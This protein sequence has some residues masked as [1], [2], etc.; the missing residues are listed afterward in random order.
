VLLFSIILQPIFNWQLDFQ[1]TFIGV[2]SHG[3]HGDAD[4]RRPETVELINQFSGVFVLNQQLY[5][6]FRPLVS[7]LHYCPNGV[8]TTV[9]RRTR[10]VGTRKKLVVG[11]VGNPDHENKKGFYEI[12]QPLRY[13]QLFDVVVANNSHAYRS[14]KDMV[15]FY[16]DIDVYLCVSETEGTPNP[17][18]EAAACGRPLL[19]TPVGNMPQFMRHGI[20]G[21]FLE[22]SLDS[23]C[24]LL[25]ELDT[26]RQLLLDMS[27][28]VERDAQFWDWSRQSENFVTML[29]MMR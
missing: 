24:S 5:N 21:F 12:V 26:N 22:R 20:N 23:V 3:A 9:F 6:D 1:R 19:T 16:N 25:G 10:P 4:P 27:H 28:Q 17:C 18:L 15:A 29:Q 14:H 13:N 11:W 8:D 7:H 2:C